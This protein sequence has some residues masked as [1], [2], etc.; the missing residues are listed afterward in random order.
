MADGVYAAVQHVQAGLR[1][2][3]VDGIEGQP[4][5]DE[6]PTGHHAVLPVR[7]ASDQL[8]GVMRPTLTAY[9]RHNVGRVSHDVHRCRPV[10]ARPL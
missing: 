5:S 10:Y 7:E 3:V 8:V 1:D 9:I 2:A 4:Q 6:L